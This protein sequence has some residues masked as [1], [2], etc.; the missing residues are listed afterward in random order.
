MGGGAIRQH[1]RLQLHHMLVRNTIYLPT[2]NT[3]FPNWVLDCCLFNCHHFDTANRRIC[4]ISISQ[5]SRTFLCPTANH[6]CLLREIITMAKNTIMLHVFSN[7]NGNFLCRVYCI[8]ARVCWSTYNGF[9]FSIPSY[10]GDNFRQADNP[11]LQ[12]WHQKFDRVKQM[13]FAYLGWYRVWAII[14]VTAI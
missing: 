1:G 3:A 14:R 6:C 10:S 11:S 13:S 5:S 8:D 12:L 2:T 4:K 9:I 7:I